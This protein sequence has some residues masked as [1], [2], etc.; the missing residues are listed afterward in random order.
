MKRL[1][2]A[3]GIFASLL[4]STLPALGQETYKAESVGAP[5]A[6]D[7]PKALVDV[8]QPQGARVLNGQGATLC[9]VWV[10]KSVPTKDA[11]GATSDTLYAGLNMG[12]LVGVLHCPNGLSDFRGQSIK[13]GYYTLRYALVPQDGNHMGVSSYRDFLVLAP[14]A[15][16]TEVE[17]PRSFEAMVPLSK[18]VSGTNHPAVLSL[19]AATATKSPNMARDDQGHW[20]LQISVPG[21]SPAGARD[22]PMGIV[23]VGKTDAA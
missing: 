4:F 17:A 16:D 14:A 12:T 19:G 8:L 1:C 11:G 15:A 10:R 20:V 18:Q 3:C 22:F 13:A 2:L 9:E 5:S 6:S 21:K 23:V 7:L